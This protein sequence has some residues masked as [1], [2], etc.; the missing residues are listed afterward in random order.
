[1]CTENSISK[2][3]F[4]HYF[5]LYVEIEAL[6]LVLQSNTN[7]CRI[8]AASPRWQGKLLVSERSIWT[9][10]SQSSKYWQRAQEPTCHLK[11]GH[12][13]AHKPRSRTTHRPGNW[14]KDRTKRAPWMELVGRQDS[15]SSDHLHQSPVAHWR[16]RTSLQTDPQQPTSRRGKADRMK[17]SLDGRSDAERRE[18]LP[19]LSEPTSR[20]ARRRTLG[21]ARKE[22]GF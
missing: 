19:S 22:K 7:L 17:D 3:V 2:N 10:M 15:Q 16:W 5:D 11:T 12:R 21:S 13:T 1:M 18:P 8:R 14:Q 6:G 20:A 4:A 9:I